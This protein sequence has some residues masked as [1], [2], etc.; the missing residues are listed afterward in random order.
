MC[1]E[2]TYAWT[3]IKSEKLYGMERYLH[4]STSII[5]R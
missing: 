3:D 4:N 5:L 1:K 2:Q